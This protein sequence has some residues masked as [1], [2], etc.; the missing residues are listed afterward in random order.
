VPPDSAELVQRSV[1]ALNRGAWDEAA[2]LARA[3]LNRFGPEANALMVLASVRTQAG[4]LREAIDLYERARAVMPTHIHVLVNL[5]SAYRAAGRLLEARETLAVAL[6]VDA[7][8]A[9]AHN[10]LANVLVDLGERQDAHRSYERAAALDSRYA[11]PVSSLAWMAEEEHRLDDAQNLA[12]RAL[13]LAPQNV[14][15]A[16][17]L[18][19]VSL[20]QGDA[21]R[22]VTIL[23]TQLRGGALSATNRVLA[24]GYL[25]E[26]YDK[27]ARYGDAFAA[28]ARANVLQHAQYAETFGQD[29][30]PLAPAAIARLTAFIE[31]TDVAAWRQA[32]PSARVPVF[33]VGFP[34]SGTTLLEQ[35]LASHRDIATL[36]E[37]DT[38][39]DAARELIN[40]TG[41]FE[42]W[43]QLGDREIERLRGL[44]W[45]R[46]GAALPS[47]PGK[48]V[49][50]DK[51]PL[52]AALLPLIYR[53]FPVAR[54]I[55]ALRDPRDAVLSCYQQR[56]DMNVAM[57][58]LLRLDTATVY[59]DV[60]MRLVET[61]RAR[62][63]L[64]L[65]VVKYEDVIG[66]FEPTIRDVLAFLHL[67][68]D[69]DV[70]HYAD[71]ARRRRVNTPSA[72]Q[73]VRPLYTSSRGKWRNY[74]D[75]LEPHLP[76]L[77]A[78]AQT[79]GYD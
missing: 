2:E 75:F 21:S 35:I 18:A 33:L 52:N 28:F 42:T 20:R 3:V 10:N 23:E 74:R 13:Q 62:L 77:S 48:G 31:R 19:R 40:A 53:L 12:E 36:E 68:W 14:L 25:G 22:A 49:C 64:C 30:G 55:L 72:S 63:P 39:T 58:Q 46:L 73:V 76:T 61:C 66:R 70:R 43:A 27:L 4:D 67:G 60:L 17:T 26:A 8:F 71:T 29:R 65:H 9:I 34:R 50:I 5:A 37:R 11:D 1:A 7:G 57:Y 51:Q 24:Q 44:Y 16:L 69:D 6:Q 15:A 41:A 45:Q 38:L 32:P 59:Y 78:W 56:F 79:F 47:A 54:V